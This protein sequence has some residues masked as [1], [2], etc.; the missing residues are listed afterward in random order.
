MRL[1]YIADLQHF[2]RANQRLFNINLHYAKL[3]KK[4]TMKSVYLFERTGEL[5]ISLE[6]LLIIF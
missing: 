4:P 3:N 2:S 1:C 6:V 5:H